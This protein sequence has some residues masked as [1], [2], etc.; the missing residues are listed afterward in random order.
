MD[1][2]IQG[3]IKR[4][5][6]ARTDALQWQRT[7]EEAY[8]YAIPQQLTYHFGA[9]NDGQSR[10]YDV[11]DSTLPDALISF[12]GKMVGGLTPQGAN[13]LKLVPGP[14]VPEEYE[15]QVARSLHDQTESFFKFLNRSNFYSVM[16]QAY[17]DWAIGTAAIIINEVDNDDNPLHF[18]CVPMDTIA[19][20]YGP[21]GTI[22]TVWRSFENFY[23]RNIEPQ[24]TG[25]KLTDMMRRKLDND[26]N[27]TINIIEG[28]VWDPNTELYSYIVTSEDGHDVFLDAEMLSS[29]WVVFRYAMYKAETFGRGVVMDLMPEVKTLN[30]MREDLMKQNELSIN[31]PIMAFGDSIANLNNIRF[32]PNSVIPVEALPNGN[33]SIQQFVNRSNYQIAQIEM[34][35]IRQLIRKMLYAEPLGGIDSPVRTAT[36]VTYRMREIAERIGPAVGLFQFEFGGP[37]VERVLHILM[38]RGLISPIIIDNKLVSIKYESPLATSQGLADA[39][40][41]EGYHAQLVQMV[42]PEAAI[43]A[44]KVDKLPMWLAEKYGV[45]PNLINSEIEIAQMA[46]SAAAPQINPGALPTQ[47]IAAMG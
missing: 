44:Y 6:K 7:L 34:D 11:Y 12:V 20:E 1:E 29:P 43:M 17:K 32:E 10:G 18:S 26:E 46:Q 8:K 41:L 33:P 42:G 47:Q 27:A 19:L 37:F 35:Q 39:A 16:P 21:F 40:A 15:E 4:Y 9:E 36:E 13:W 14:D 23:L 22:K 45:D 30:K 3:Y 5:N 2:K 28:T 38:K 24:W 25:A 31:P